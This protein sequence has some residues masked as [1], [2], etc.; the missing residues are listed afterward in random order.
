MC[1]NDIEEYCLKHVFQPVDMKDAF[2]NLQSI[3]DIRSKMRSNEKFC[4]ALRNRFHTMRICID[5]THP[6]RV[7]ENEYL[8]L[9]VGLDMEPKNDEWTLRVHEMY[10]EDC[11]KYGENI[12]L[13]ESDRFMDIQIDYDKIKSALQDILKDEYIPGKREY[14]FPMF[15]KDNY[16]LYKMKETLPS[17]CILDDEL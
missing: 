14:S 2:E 4:N 11:I 15:N 6:F 8:Q 9:T 1:T 3:D 7:T 10:K 17:Y 13:T 16:N 12:P 5:F